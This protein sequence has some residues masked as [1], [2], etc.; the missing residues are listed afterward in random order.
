MSRSAH[1]RSALGLGRFGAKFAAPGEDARRDQR[2]PQR[3]AWATASSRLWTAS[4]PR[5]F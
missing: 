2:S 4:F 1:F 5:M 3:V